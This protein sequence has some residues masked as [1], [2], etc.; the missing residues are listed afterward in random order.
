M[1]LFVAFAVI[2]TSVSPGRATNDS[3]GSGVDVVE[4]WS[5]RDE[6]GFKG[7]VFQF[8]G[9]GISSDQTDLIADTGDVPPSDTTEGPAP[10]ETTTLVASTQL[11]SPLSVPALAISALP[12]SEKTR[13]VRENTITSGLTPVYTTDPNYYYEYYVNHGTPPPDENNY[14]FYGPNVDPGNSTAP[15]LNYTENLSDEALPAAGHTDSVQL[16]N[17]NEVVIKVSTDA[18]QNVKV[19]YVLFIST[20][21]ITR[22]DLLSD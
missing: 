7:D 19:Q 2:F 12:P 14:Q 5:N 18:A 21:F 8:F 16:D 4:P 22:L 3:G 13:N 20:V 17:I 6:G 9:Q 10:D 1:Y 11:P 15:I